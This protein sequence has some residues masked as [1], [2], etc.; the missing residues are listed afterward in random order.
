MLN[1]IIL[2]AGVPCIPPMHYSAVCETAPA[3]ETRKRLCIVCHIKHSINADLDHSSSSVD[4]AWSSHIAASQLP[5][6][7]LCKCSSITKLA[8]PVVTLAR[9]I[10]IILAAADCGGEHTVVPAVGSCSWITFAHRGAR[11]VRARSKLELSL[12]C[13]WCGMQKLSPGFCHSGWIGTDRQARRFWSLHM[14][15]CGQRTH[16]EGSAHTTCSEKCQDDISL[17]WHNPFDK[18]TFL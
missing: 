12:L 8:T 4:L 2:T 7:L 10:H 3:R 18:Y 15:F 13:L 6:L 11:L 9:H 16:P 14:S 5:Q 17:D 1:V